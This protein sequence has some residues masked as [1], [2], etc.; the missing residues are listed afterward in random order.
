M[1]KF[2]IPDDQIIAEQLGLNQQEMAQRLLSAF[3]VRSEE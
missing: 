2:G 1:K 3:C